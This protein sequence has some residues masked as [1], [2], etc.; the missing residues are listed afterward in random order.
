MIMRLKPEREIA[1][2][3]LVQS[4]QHAQDWTADAARHEQGQHDDERHDARGDADNREPQGANAGKRLGRVN[5][6][7]QAQSHLW[8]P[9]IDA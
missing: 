8:N 7:Q 6:R 4:R 2:P 5:F 1:P 9:A 3:D